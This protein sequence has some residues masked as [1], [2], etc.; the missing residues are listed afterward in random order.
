M[1]LSIVM[2]SHYVECHIFFIFMLNV[3]VLSAYML[4]VTLLSFY[5]LNVVM[6]SVIKT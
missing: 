4:N 2:F 3:I 6:L 5:T 1:S